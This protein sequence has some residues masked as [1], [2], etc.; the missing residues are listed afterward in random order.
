MIGDDYSIL[1]DETIDGVRYI[2]AVPSSLVCSVQIDFRLEDGKIHDLTYT[3]GC[4]GNLRAIG[5]LLEGKDARE[6]A[7]ILSGVDC[8]GRGTSCSDQLSR[9]LNSINSDRS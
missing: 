6:A 1:R 8:H 2:S 3:R 5:R 7:A 4:E 9:I